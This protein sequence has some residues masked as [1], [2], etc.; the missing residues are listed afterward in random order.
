MNNENE[1]PR[2]P[3]GSEDQAQPSQ[4]EPTQAQH[5]QYGAPTS[6]QNQQGSQYAQPVQYA[7]PGQYSQYSQYGQN[8][9]SPYA[10]GMT[11]PFGQA[12]AQKNKVGLIALIVSIAGLVLGC[13][14]FPQ[15]MIF[16]WIVMFA[17]FITGIVAVAQ[18]GKTKGTGIAAICTSVV[19]SI[20][21]LVIFF[22]VLAFAIVDD[23]S[24]DSYS[25]DGFS[26]YSSASPSPS[27]ATPAPLKLGET[28]KF[29]DGISVTVSEGKDFKPS[30]TAAG[31]SD[32][33]R[34]VFRKYKVTVKNDSLQSFKI[35][36][37]RISAKAA[38]QDATSVFD[39]SAN[40]NLPSGTVLPG[41]EYSFEAGFAMVK[42]EDV[43]VEVSFNFER[44]EVIFVQ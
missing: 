4:S 3:S 24:S 34:K 37:S 1:P 32:S 35:K 20:I 39:S 30:E 2:Y 25:A 17:G 27:F 36:S 9:Q 15:V 28:Y 19:G 38:G 23:V 14:P 29:E 5:G 42:N 7:Q 44:P 13:I 33:T 11:V 16:G 26:E 22:A 40:L 6:G 43:S 21:S 10:P 31:A 41:K 12:T 18:S 8:P